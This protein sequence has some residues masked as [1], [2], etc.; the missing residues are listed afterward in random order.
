MDPGVNI[1][2]APSFYAFIRGTETLWTGPGVKDGRDYEVSD[3]W[4]VALVRLE[5]VE[6]SLGDVLGNMRP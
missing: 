6:R 3:V 2:P 1:A 4:I 5:V